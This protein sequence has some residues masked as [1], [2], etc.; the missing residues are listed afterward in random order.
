MDSGFD[1]F[2]SLK[3]EF[4]KEK[5]ASKNFASFSSGSMPI[6]PPSS[7]QP[8][9]EVV[10]IEEGEEV[11]EEEEQDFGAKLGEVDPSELL[12]TVGVLV[13][14]V[15]D[16]TFTELL[17]DVVC[18]VMLPSGDASPVPSCCGGGILLLLLSSSASASDADEAS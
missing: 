14:K 18:S 1:K 6:P 11:E 4:N 17:P 2:N 12:L 8:E 10:G 15:D 5:N 3:V 9:D 7:L 13:L 16:G